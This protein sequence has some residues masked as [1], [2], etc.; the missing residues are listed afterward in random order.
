MINSI[1]LLGADPLDELAQFGLDEAISTARRYLIAISSSEDFVT[2]VAIAF[3]DSIDAAKAEGLRQEWL[4]GNFGSL[5]A[6]EIRSAAE[7]NGA[8]GAFSAD[9]NTIYLSR[10]YIEQN[11]SDV[12]AIAN[13][14]LEEIGHSVDSRIN[15]SDAPG[16]EGAIFSA[17]AQGVQIDTPTLQALKA[18]DDT[19]TIT[20][21]GQTI[22]IEQDSLDLK[23]IVNGLDTL[24]G[25]IG[26]F[27]I[28]LDDKFSGLKT[29]ISNAKSE[30]GKLENNAASE[31]I[32]ETLDE[33][34]DQVL[35]ESDYV[36]ANGQF[37]LNL[38]LTTDFGDVPGIPSIYSTFNL[39]WSLTNP[40]SAANIAFKDVKLDLGSFFQDFAEPVIGKVNQ[41]IKPF[42]PLRKILTTNVPGLDSIGVNINLLSLAQTLGTE[43]NE[44]LF[45]AL[46][47]FSTL[48][49]AVETATSKVQ[50]L[51]S[52]ARFIN[53]GEFSLNANGQIATSTPFSIAP[54]AQAEEKGLSFFSDSKKIPGSGFIFPLLEQSNTAFNLLLGQDVGLL[55]FKLPEFKAGF[56]FQKKFL[57]PTPLPIPVYANFGGDATFT[58]PGLTFGYDTAGLK[59]NVPLQG[60]Y[61]NGNQSIFHVET[62]LKAGASAGVPKFAEAGGDVFIQ[63]EADFYLPGRKEKVR[64]S[65][66]DDLFNT[67]FFETQGKVQAGASL[68]AE[69]FTFN[70]IKGLFGALTGDF[71]KLVDR[72]EINLVT[73]DLFDF[74]NSGGSG[75]PQ[76]PPNLASFNS[77]NGELLLNI[78]SRAAQRN[79]NKDVVDEQF[80]ITPN[81]VVA[82]FGYKETYSGVSKVVAN[83]GTGNDV[84][85]VEVNVSAELHGGSGHDSL[86]G[87]SKDDQLFGEEGEDRLIGRDGNDK[88]YGGENNDK[89][90]GD[91]GNDELRGDAGDDFLDGGANNDY[92]DGGD[93]KDTLVGSVGDDFLDGGAN[94]DYLYGGNG[95]DTL[96]GSDGEDILAGGESDDNLD[97]GI[98]KDTLFGEVGTDTLLGGDQDDLLDGGEGDDTLDGGAGDDELV[99][100]FRIVIEQSVDQ[101]GQPV[102]SDPE[103]F[104]DAGRD[105]LNGGEGNDTLKGSAGND[106]LDGGVG[107]D[108]LFGED[109]NDL[110]KG[111]AGNDELTGGMG[112]DQLYGGLDN[113]TLKGYTD[114]DQLAGGAGA[115]NL[116]GNAGND[117]LYG[118][119]ADDFLMGE[120]ADD[121]I[122]GGTEVDTVNYDNSPSGVIVNI[123]EQQNYQNLGG[124]LHTTILSTSL[125][126]TDT[127]PDFIINAGIAKDGFG[128]TDTLRNLENIIGSKYDDVLI[129]NSQDNRIEALAGDDLLIGNAGN[130]YLDGGDG[131]DTVSYRRDPNQAQVKV[132]LEQNQATDGF[133]GNDQLHNI[134]NV[135]GSFFDDEII[136]DAKANII[137]AGEGNDIVQARDGN[138]II[139]GEQGQ[140]ALF[141]ENGDDFLVGGKDADTLNGGAGNDTASYFTSASAVAVRLTTATGWSGDADSDSII[142]VEN[143][144]GSQFDDYLEGNKVGNLLSGLRGND[145]LLGMSGNDTLNGGLGNDLLDGGLGNDLLN[146][147]EGNDDFHGEQG[148][149]TLIGGAGND[150]LDGESD[151]DI[152]D[153][154]TGD[155]YVDGGEGNDTLDGGL[156]DDTVD[157]DEGHDLLNA[158]DGNDILIGAQG[159][160]TLYAGDGNDS[161][162]GGD[163]KDILNA[164]DGNDFLDGGKGSDFLD[165]GAGDDTLTGGRSGNDTLYAGEGNDKLHSGSGTDILDGGAGNDTLDASEGN[166][167]ISGGLGNDFIDAGSDN[168]TLDGG[169]GDDEL[170][171]ESGMDKLFGQA[172]ND[173]LD[174]GSDN[175]YLWGGE[176]F[177]T[178]LGQDGNDYLV[179]DSGDDLLK[180]GDGNDTLFGG[181]GADTLYG[182]QGRDIF[183]LAVGSGTD[184][185]V[186]FVVGKDSLGLSGG[187]S[188]KELTISQGMSDQA[189]D[190]LI[191]LTATG[192]L[193]ATLTDVDASSLKSSNFTKISLT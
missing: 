37:N 111:D 62:T 118:E 146:G 69:H 25:V 148:N 175:D 133:G 94:N 96:Q 17:L 114:D 126:P 182:N 55:E 103:I 52:D 59:S 140:D 42:E 63:G 45:K 4:A 137:H 106:T 129:G 12:S 88:L 151:N 79:V 156:G 174:A 180:G 30:L 190:T 47:Q 155:D 162:T 38:N 115:D 60:F 33:A 5:P 164:G 191:S 166:D 153:G 83:A 139:F 154:G 34:L 85:S 80:S 76:L 165:S 89:L 73:I 141:G 36:N 179:G 1:S 70:P 128:T 135:I 105:F 10:E 117:T 171:A 65:E 48:V 54:L 86:Y 186:D 14:L 142:N 132:N 99:G 138:D 6:I 61:I 101:D 66:L 26:K 170:F 24:E 160:D 167:S 75:T 41:I 15:V 185:F 127:E 43:Y 32:R 124:S 104:D 120:A 173:Y 183:A 78:G 13:V 189:K 95:K 193:L 21:E 152:L 184:T 181:L 116:N 187:L 74:G 68:W 72:H 112:N 23:A 113:D 50:S 35:G 163:G 110:L 29:A 64:L 158:G 18:E 7:I 168:D 77:N 102:F 130:D 149:D 136:G 67:G 119:A 109:G 57:I 16:D 107:N 46:D 2:K 178:L 31:L 8:N 44:D 192:E 3:G 91:K 20:L 93:G 150:Y 98:G 97:G 11:G 159:N 71:E 40:S 188:F 27:E 19:A 121:L 131:N 108:K 49:T 176:G 157:G 125:V 169:G 81:V 144:E 123:D 84:I 100:G 58:S 172:G 177:D 56:N 22:H 51:S 39:G 134:E 87:G 90:Y 92:L 82:A 28:A 122:D 145:T 147:E 53:L 9:T 161:L 143:L